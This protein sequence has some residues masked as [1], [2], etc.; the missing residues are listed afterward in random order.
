MLNVHLGARQTDFFLDLQIV[1]GPQYRCGMQDLW[2]PGLG[3]H[4]GHPSDDVPCPSQHLL[5]LDDGRVLPYIDQVS[6]VTRRPPADAGTVILD[7]TDIGMPA[8][9]PRT[10]VMWPH[11]LD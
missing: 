10:L 11:A 5:A 3:S 6:Q 7:W 2:G 1:G 9:G 4:A 8:S